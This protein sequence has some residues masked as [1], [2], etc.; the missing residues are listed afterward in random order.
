MAEKNNQ[1]ELK[2]N[3]HKYREAQAD[4][5]RKEVKKVVKGTV[6]KRKKPLS[7]KIA[8]TFMAEDLND[9]KSHVFFDVIVP[10]I[11]DTLS[12][13]IKEAVDMFF[14]GSG[15][16][17]RSRKNKP[18]SRVSYSSYYDRD[19]D[20]KSRRSGNV[21]SRE[22]YDIVLDSRLEAE[23]VLDS[24]RDIIDQYGQASLADYHDLCGVSGSYTDNKYGWT[25]LTRANVTL[26]RGQ[27]YIVDLPKAILLDY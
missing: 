5:Q 12:E 17:N 10:S 14:H 26:V 18:Y 16:S 9:V 6:K 13:S 21:P 24:L 15:K 1:V 23:E 8:E 22:F 7:K 19:D 4:S 27:G 3:S 20:R 2:P 11:K 25:D